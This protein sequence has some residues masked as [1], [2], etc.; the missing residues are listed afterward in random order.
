MLDVSFFFRL[1]FWR[2][3]SPKRKGIYGTSEV[4]VIF[5]FSPCE[6][7]SIFGCLDG[8]F[9]TKKWIGR[10]QASEE[11]ASTNR[12]LEIEVGRVI[13]TRTCDALC[14]DDG[15][16]IFRDPM[17]SARL[18]KYVKHAVDKEPQRVATLVQLGWWSWNQ[19]IQTKE[20]S[21][22]QSKNRRRLGLRKNGLK[23]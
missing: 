19:W 13:K 17:G 1:A 18:G 22:V 12:R 8:G 3:F 14:R 20:S 5:I 6:V 4:H 23:C 10:R 15:M 21:N 7:A 9:V 16:G 11:L 2:R